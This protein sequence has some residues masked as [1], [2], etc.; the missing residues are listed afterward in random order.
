MSKRNPKPPPAVTAAMFGISGMLFR[1]RVCLYQVQ[2]LMRPVDYRGLSMPPTET[3]EGTAFDMFLA[4]DS[5]GA[6]IAVHRLFEFIGDY[7]LPDPTTPA[8][9]PL[10]GQLLEDFVLL[11]FQ[12]IILDDPKG[13]ITYHANCDAMPRF[14]R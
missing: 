4:V 2:C 14:D 1:D 12:S 11:N 5:A 3:P 13:E 10:F 6:I 9:R 7:M 8:L